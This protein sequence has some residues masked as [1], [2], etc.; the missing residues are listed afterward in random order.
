MTSF[1]RTA[2]YLDHLE[3]PDDCHDPFSS[4]SFSSQHSQSF[5]G[6][7]DQY[8]NVGARDWNHVWNE[9]IGDPTH[10]SGIGHGGDVEE[11]DPHTNTFF[12]AIDNV[13]GHI[14]SWFANDL[15]IGPFGDA[16]ALQIDLG[17]TV[18]Q[19]HNDF[20]RCYGMIYRAK[21]K[22]QG[23]MSEVSRCLRE[24]VPQART[25]F[26]LDII[27]ADEQLY[28]C[29]PG[30]MRIATLN[31]HLTEALMEHV[32]VQ[33][34]RLEALVHRR[35]IFDDIGAA[36]KAN[37]AVTTININVYGTEESQRDIGHDLSV[38]KVWLQRPDWVSPTSTYDNPHVL[39]L[40]TTQSESEVEIPCQIE[41]SSRT[42]GFQESVEEMY[43]MLQRD[44]HLQGLAGDARLGTE[45]LQHQKKALDFMIQRETGPIPER[46]QL[47][48]ATTVESEPCYRHKIAG[49]KS[50]VVP[51]ETGGGILADEMGMGKTYSMLAL[52]VRT[53]D[54][55]TKWSGDPDAHIAEEILPTKILS[56]ATLVVVPSP[57]LLATW[58]NEFIKRV[59]L[60]LKLLKYHG[61]GRTKDPTVMADNDIVLTTYHTLI[62][63]KHRSNPAT[64]VAWYRIILDEA[65]FIRRNSTFLHKGVAELDAKFR[66]CLTGTPIQNTLDDIGSLFAFLK[67]F[68]F[69]RL[70][71]FRRYITVPFNEGGNRRLDGQQNLAH[72]FDSLC[73]RRTKEHLNLAVPVER[74]RPIQLS[75]EERAQYQKTKEDMKRTLQ[76]LV[77]ASETQSRFSMFQAQLQLRLLCNHGTFQHQFHWAKSRNTRDAR[78]DAVNSAGTDGEIKCS[79][80]GQTVHTVLSTRPSGLSTICTHVLCAECKEGTGD[81]CPM[82]E[83]TFKPLR[84]QR[85][86]AGAISQSRLHEGDLRSEGRSSK[87][88][89]LVEDLR[90]AAADGDKSI[91]FSCWTTTLDLIGKHL[92]YSGVTFERIDGEHSVEHRQSVLARFETDPHI[93]V[94]IMTTGVGAFGLSII[95]ASR[96]FL[97]EPQWNPSVEAQAIGRAIRI[98]Q[99][100]AVQVTR[101]VVENSVEESILKLQQRKRGIAKMTTKD[102]EMADT[103]IKPEHEAFY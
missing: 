46:F 33:K 79:A 27:C 19:P 28:V 38:K 86:T 81:S 8:I 87:M 63:D 22:L 3:Y 94:L 15:G 72:L 7:S 35:T 5:D 21:A 93:P 97:V 49:I 56:R 24:D 80:C 50:R 23:V 25:H 74:T 52:I 14:E 43:S 26:I 68:P 89:A 9:L 47:W 65:H 29:I 6:G 83:A 71:I 77:G 73:I 69:D 64:E 57:I 42:S 2:D 103:Y 62:A 34:I 1:K 102:V 55:A 66:W 78:E 75:P 98:G 13:Q 96:V 100:K 82:C 12:S 76:Q 4:Q 31:V 90:S 44:S 17:D 60:P 99:E 36:T 70:G 37:E 20:N 40:G 59:N 30:G 16:D 32:K 54:E 84:H 58:E 39:R 67:I 92:Y 85:H 18:G 45:L 41:Q 53:L 51:A 91:V 101:Y 48:E 11:A 10:E 95:A 88:V 61:S